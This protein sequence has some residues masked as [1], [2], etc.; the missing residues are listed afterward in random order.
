MP[1]Q[2]LN[3]SQIYPVRQQRRCKRMAQCVRRYIIRQLQNYPQSL[4]HFLRHAR[5]HLPAFFANEQIA[6]IKRPHVYIFFNRLPDDRQY[7][8]N[9]LF[10]ARSKAN[11]P[12]PA[13]AFLRVCP[14]LCAD[15]PQFSGNIPPMPER[16]SPI[17]H[18]NHAPSYKN[19]APS[20]KNYA[21]SH[22]NHAP[23][24]KNYGTGYPQT[25]DGVPPN[26]GRSIKIMERRP[27]NMQRCIQF[28]GLCIF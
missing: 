23:S 21:A 27:Q 5:A 2:F 17:F 26:M 14:A 25:W 13:P 3:A 7:W 11:S 15:Q 8:N 22:K 28:I 12:M 9:A 10:R 16:R 4:Y 19:H 18:K 1:Q 20:Y 6:G 24:Y